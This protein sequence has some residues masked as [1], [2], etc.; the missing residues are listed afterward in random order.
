MRP[1]LKEGANVNGTKY[2]FQGGAKLW[3]K[4]RKS[5]IEV[6]LSRPQ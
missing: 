5:K 1:R 4:L 3:L 2:T 6:E